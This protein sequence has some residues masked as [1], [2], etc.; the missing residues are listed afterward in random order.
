MRRQIQHLLVSRLRIAADRKAYPEIAAAKIERPIF[1]SGFARSG[2]T[3]LHALLAEDPDSLAPSAWH[4]R[5]PSP[6]PGLMPACSGRIAYA[7]KSAYQL[8][9]D[10]ELLTLDFRNAYPSLRSAV[11]AATRI[12]TNRLVSASNGSRSSLPT[13]VSVSA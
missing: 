9:E 7:D 8:I 10:E 3:L 5:M 11:T 6:P 13:T 2:T 1:V 12:P 4:S